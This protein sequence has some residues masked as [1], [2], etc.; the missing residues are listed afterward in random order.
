LDFDISRFNT[1]EEKVTNDNLKAT[2]VTSLSSLVIKS[3]L[4]RDELLLHH[5]KSIKIFQL[6][7]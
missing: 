7:E 3:E 6:E 1:H 5:R 2:I 4:L